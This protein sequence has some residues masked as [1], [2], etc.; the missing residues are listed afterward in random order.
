MNGSRTLALAAAMLVC[1]WMP[2]GADKRPDAGPYAILAGTVFRDPGFALA[3]ASVTLTLRDD[4]RG[5]KLQQAV[6]TPRG[7][8][9]GPLAPGARSEGQEAAASRDHAARGILISRSCT[10]RRLPREG[11]AE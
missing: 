6:T 11:G 10:S 5:K 7:G 4:P 9:H 8:C 3:D 2:A 1:G